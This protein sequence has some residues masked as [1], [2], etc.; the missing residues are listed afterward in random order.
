MPAAQVETPTALPEKAACCRRE[1]MGGQIKI[2]IGPKH[3]P[4]SSLE[5]QLSDQG[6][7]LN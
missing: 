2:K 7:G 3:R 4:C 1:G 5:H 6:T